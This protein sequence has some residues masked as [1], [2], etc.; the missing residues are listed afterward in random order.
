[1][2][3][4]AARTALRERINFA[5]PAITLSALA[6]ASLIGEDKVKSTL[7]SGGGDPFGNAPGVAEARAKKKER[8]AKVTR[9]LAIFSAA[10]LARVLLPS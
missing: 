2:E 8:E 3:D 5:L 10:C 4:N 6:I 7:S 9:P 1:V